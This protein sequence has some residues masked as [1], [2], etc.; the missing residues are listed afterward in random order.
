MNETAEQLE[1]W[2]NFSVWKLIIQLLIAC[3][4]QNQRSSIN[5]KF[6]LWRTIDNILS[7]HKL[8]SS[9]SPELSC[10]CSSADFSIGLRFIFC[11]SRNLLKKHKHYMIKVTVKKLQISNNLQPEHT[12]LQLFAAATK[13]LK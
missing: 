5:I 7:W 6:E 11:R 1:S 9:L 13:A 2:N 12:K 4:Y 8:T 10:D 3:S